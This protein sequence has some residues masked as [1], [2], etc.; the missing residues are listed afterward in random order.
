MATWN[1]IFLYT[2]LLFVGVQIQV[3]MQETT[4]GISADLMTTVETTEEVNTTESTTETTTTTYPSTT[5]HDE[6]TTTVVAPTVLCYDGSCSSNVT[7][8]NDDSCINDTITTTCQ[9]SADETCFQTVY[10]N[11]TDLI[12]L[13]GC[14][15]NC[16]YMVEEGQGTDTVSTTR[17]CDTNMCNGVLLPDPSSENSAVSM[18]SSLSTVVCFVVY[19]MM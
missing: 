6:T 16:E 19:M 12:F 13:V 5:D 11:N 2:G 15:S 3:S 17:C 14:K 18:T 7:D 1:N 4:Q 9:L 8:G 10:K